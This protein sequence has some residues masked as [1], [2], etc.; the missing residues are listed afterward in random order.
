MTDIQKAA[1]A[2]L[3]SR[4]DKGEMTFHD[5]T[6]KAG[7]EWQAKKDEEIINSFFSREAVVEMWKQYCYYV[8]NLPIGQ[9]ASFEEWFNTNYPPKTQQ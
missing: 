2:H 7:A 4:H 8:Q 5:E 6:F 1:A 3:K 9:F